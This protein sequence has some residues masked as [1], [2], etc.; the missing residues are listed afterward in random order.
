[1]NG[2]QNLHTF[3]LSA[4]VG[5]VGVNTSKVTD[6]AT[7][8]AN[9]KGANFSTSGANV[10][11]TSNNTVTQNAKV[12][13]VTAGFVASG[14][15]KLE[16][17]RSMNNEISLVNSGT[18][19]EFGTVNTVANTNSN[20]TL[21][22]ISGTGGVLDISPEAARL[23]DTS[24]TTTKISITGDYNANTINV[25]AT[26]TENGTRKVDATSASVAGYS[27]ATSKHSGT[28]LTAIKKMSS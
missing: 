14:T 2:A 20:A 17:V 26:T 27:G 3:A 23:D 6:N 11:V 10:N 25:A 19:K 9:L 5:A 12:T 4:G 1:M 7:T 13:G 18:N 22:A 24:N 16:S 15:S 28:T 8:M 21:S